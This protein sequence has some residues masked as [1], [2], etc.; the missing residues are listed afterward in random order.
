MN[1]SRQ[2]NQNSNNSLKKS[3]PDKVCRICFESETKDDPIITPCDCRGSMQH[4]HEKCLKT[5]ILAQS[6]DPKAFVC[7][8]CKSQVKMDIKLKRVCS[9]KRVRTEMVK[10]CF[11]HG[12]ILVTSSVIVVL[13]VL[14]L[15]ENTDTSLSDKIYIAVA[16]LVCLCIDIAMIIILCRSIK[17]SCFERTVKSWKIFSRTATVTPADL[18]QVTEFYDRKKGR[19]MT[20]S[21]E[22][23]GGVRE[24]S[25]MINTFKTGFSFTQRHELQNYFNENHHTTRIPNQVS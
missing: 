17:R 15:R 25:F 1:D 13:V 8:V 22:N 9:C 6:P 19:T 3:L 5:W 21:V 18:T 14:L 7:D 10:L 23:I 24:E 16:L 4:I 11:V 12:M 2:F 20:G